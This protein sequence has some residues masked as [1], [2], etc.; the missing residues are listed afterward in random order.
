MKKLLLI[1]TKNTTMKKI[2]FT[3]IGFFFISNVQSQ[4]ITGFSNVIDTDGNTHDLSSYLN[5][6][7]H[8]ILNFYL[9]TCGNCMATAP[10][11]ELIYNDYGQNQCNV[12]V[13]S[14]LIDNSTVPPPTNIDCDNWAATYGNPSPPNFNYTEAD[15][16]QFYAI[17]GG[18]FAQ[19]YLITPNGDSV[20]YA[21]AGGVLDHIALRGVLDSIPEL[22]STSN[23]SATNSYIWNGITYTSSGVYTHTTTNSNG[24]DSTATL[25]LTIT[26]VSSAL[27]IKRNSKIIFK[28]IDVLGREVK[29]T[30]N[31][32][33]FYIYNDGT[34]EKRIVIE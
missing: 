30:K 24:C 11:I 23:L 9:L 15:W 2:L 31:K 17:H 16:Y 6:G 33:L 20:I 13:L 7:K 18:G 28:I 12:I 27:D 10:E 21:H 19:T 22:T 34:V 4:V 5:E 8:V 25:H 32:P 14:F 26:N 3:L 1:L 29:G